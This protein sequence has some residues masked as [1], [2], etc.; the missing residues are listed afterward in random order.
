MSR[1]PTLHLPDEQP[2][3]GGQYG[4]EGRDSIGVKIIAAPLSR[5]GVHYGELH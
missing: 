2:P 3:L 1:L 4:T 5:G